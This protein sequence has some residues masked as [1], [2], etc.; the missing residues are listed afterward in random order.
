M[1]SK[2]KR[3]E[4]EQAT[5]AALNEALSVEDAQNAAQVMLREKQEEEEADM[6][7]QLALETAAKIKE[8]TA[9]KFEEYEKAKVRCEDDAQREWLKKEY[10]EHVA[11]ITKD[12]EQAT[13]ATQAE[14]FAKL[15]A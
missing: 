8:L 5:L 2:K 6:R 15:R 7:A 11:K 13:S 9:A 4:L 10:E 14:E 3:E 12:V 1:G